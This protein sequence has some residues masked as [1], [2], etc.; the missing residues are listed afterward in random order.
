MKTEFQKVLRDLVLAY[1][2]EVNPAKH[3]YD[4]AL[5]LEEF[6]YST[7]E[8]RR[9][10]EW[11]AKDMIEKSDL[12]RDRDLEKKLRKDA[13]DKLCEASEL[14]SELAMSDDGVMAEKAKAWLK[15]NDPWRIAK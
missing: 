12:E 15:K 9:A 3:W 14:L 6:D 7:K 2:R 8:Y 13:E 4:T 5:T 1:E 11:L 10:K